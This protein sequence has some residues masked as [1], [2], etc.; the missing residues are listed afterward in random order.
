M[1]WAVFYDLRVPAV[2]Y[3]TAPLQSN[4]DSYQDNGGYSTVYQKSRFA[5][6]EFFLTLDLKGFLHGLLLDI[7]KKL[8][9][10]RLTCAKAM[11]F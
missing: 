10:P 11:F 8:R 7:K 2:A 5:V 1:W 6:S 3:S 4:I 9:Q